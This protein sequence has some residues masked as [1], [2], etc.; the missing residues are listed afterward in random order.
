MTA[1]LPQPMLR[2]AATCSV[3]RQAD[4]LV[5]TVR[6]HDIS[7]MSNM[8]RLL[9]GHELSLLVL[10]SAAVRGLRDMTMKQ[11]GLQAG[12]QQKWHAQPHLPLRNRSHSRILRWL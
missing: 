2:S 11:P 7:N 10:P 5:V 8:L 6:P 4:A 1:C 3:H 9:R 12:D